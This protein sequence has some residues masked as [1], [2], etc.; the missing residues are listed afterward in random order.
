MTPGRRRAMTCAYTPDGAT[1][2][3]QQNVLLPEYFKSLKVGDV[4]DNDPQIPL[5]YRATAGPEK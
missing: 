1:F 2:N 5:I 3:G 4:L